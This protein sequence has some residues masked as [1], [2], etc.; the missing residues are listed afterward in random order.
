MDT[1]DK[2]KHKIEAFNDYHTLSF[3]EGDLHSVLFVIP[4]LE[5]SFSPLMR[6]P[7]VSSD[8]DRWG[9]AEAKNLV[10][11]HVFK[12]TGINRTLQSGGHTFLVLKF[13]A[14]T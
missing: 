7:L 4:A 10:L 2:L 11:F 14:L 1:Q 9:Y 5:A 8:A 13:T 6:G 3:D 12:Q